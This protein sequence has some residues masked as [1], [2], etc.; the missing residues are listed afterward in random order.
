MRGS[1][2]DV[3]IYYVV[4]G[5]GR[6]FALAPATTAQYIPLNI[7]IIP[8]QYSRCGHRYSKSGFTHLRM[9]DTI[10]DLH[11]VNKHE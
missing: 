4:V 6:G 5:N 8:I 9:S 11:G 1:S 3:H 7:R 10:P 2:N